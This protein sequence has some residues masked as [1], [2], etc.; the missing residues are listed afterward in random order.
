MDIQTRSAIDKELLILIKLVDG[1]QALSI[2][3]TINS[4]IL[5]GVGVYDISKDI[6]RAILEKQKFISF[7]D[8]WR[9]K[10]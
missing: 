8:C 5:A 10:T 4:A 3:K 9:E 1:Y 7:K 6:D 2:L